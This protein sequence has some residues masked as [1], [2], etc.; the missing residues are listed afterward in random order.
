M[1]EF[2]ELPREP[3]CPL[4]LW[5]GGRDEKGEQVQVE[6][7]VL[8]TGEAGECSAKHRLTRLYWAGGVREEHPRLTRVF[9][10]VVPIPD[11]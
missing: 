4:S 6:L 7:L 1:A 2:A 11:W 9:T 5:G 8:M 10:S 3:R